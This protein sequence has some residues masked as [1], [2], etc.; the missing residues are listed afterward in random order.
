MQA[1]RFLRTLDEDELEMLITF[2]GAAADKH[3][4]QVV[5][6]ERFLLGVCGDQSALSLTGS[7]GQ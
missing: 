4:R 2:V 3:E 1:T 7:S 5:G 6:E